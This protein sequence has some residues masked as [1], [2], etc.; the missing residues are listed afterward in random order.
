M[1]LC[2]RVRIGNGALYC[3]ERYIL[4]H[5]FNRL[6]RG[7]L[8][9][10]YRR[11]LI[12]K[13]YRAIS[14]HTACVSILEISL[15]IVLLSGIISSTVAGAKTR[16]ASDLT[17]TIQ[18]Y[19]LCCRRRIGRRPAFPFRLRQT[20]GV[21]SAGRASLLHRQTGSIPIIQRLNDSLQRL[22][23]THTGSSVGRSPP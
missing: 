21:S 14:D 4:H 20:L 3:P 19:G 9:R 5:S 15:L 17:K 7:K 8:P 16:R 23:R 11:R 22:L 12:A 1:A 2:K 18:P 6:Q 10:Q 13:I